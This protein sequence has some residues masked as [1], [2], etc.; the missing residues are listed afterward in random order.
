MK[1]TTKNTTKETTKED[2]SL[3]INKGIYILKS[4]SRPHG[5]IHNSELTLKL[6]VDYWNKKYTWR[7][8]NKIDS[9][10][11]EIESMLK[12]AKDFAQRMIESKSDRNF[13]K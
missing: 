6:F 1:A 8:L 13:Y 2:R 11:T 3:R 4:S 9:D 12:Y 5:Q 10:K 7:W